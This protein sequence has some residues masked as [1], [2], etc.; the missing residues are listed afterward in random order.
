MEISFLFTLRYSL[1]NILYIYRIEG[2]GGVSATEKAQ[3]ILNNLAF[4]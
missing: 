1:I 4:S 3:I 2:D